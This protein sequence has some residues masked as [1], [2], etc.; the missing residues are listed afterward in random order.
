MSDE[1]QESFETGSGSSGRPQGRDP[2]SQPTESKALMHRGDD[3]TEPESTLPEG[4]YFSAA[5]GRGLERDFETD[6]G[7]YE[8]ERIGFEDFGT[9]AFSQGRELREPYDDLDFPGR[10]DRYAGRSGSSYYPE[11]DYDGAYDW[12]SPTSPQRTA[13]SLLRWSN[14]EEDWV[15]P[16]RLRSRQAALARDAMVPQPHSARRTDTLRTVARIMR[17]QNVG[18][19]PVVDDENRLLGL[20]T[21]RDIVRVRTN[22]SERPWQNWRADE[23]MSDDIECVTPEEPLHEVMRLMS[24]K[25]VHLV[26]VIDRGDRLLG[27]ISLADI[28]QRGRGKGPD[29]GDIEA[30]H[31]QESSGRRSF[32]SRLWH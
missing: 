21:D 18:V 8:R 3:G 31:R 14:S 13:P 17:E 27:M 11:E 6:T 7:A 23:V 29:R 9:P 19:V 2:G 1:N 26:P 22:G 24:R 20:I 25:R 4:R 12:G 10:D 28:V 16:S 5:R 32:W 30:R 15:S